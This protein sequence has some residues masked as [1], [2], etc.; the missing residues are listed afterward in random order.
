MEI[1]LKFEELS[2][3]II[4][5][6]HL[7]AESSTKYLLEM[8][9]DPKNILDEALMKGMGIVGQRFRDQQIFVPQ[10]L[11]SA[12]AMKFSMK[13]LEPYLVGD[14]ALSKGKVLLGTVKGDVHDIGKN[15][16]AIML[17]GSGYEVIDIGTGCSAEK[18]YDE[19]LKHKTDIVGMSA[20]LT[21]T[22]VYMKTV[23]EFFKEKNVMVPIIIGGAPL[24]QRFA[25]E[26]GADGFGRNSYDA[27][28]LVDKILNIN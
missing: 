9:I 22:M 8:G 17:Q 23:I 25:D 24:N 2:N 19:Y 18:F 26:I 21:T 15:L 7:D 27:V 13:A 20:L 12:R 28:K 4:E 16:V 1:G 6:K 14:N 3:M 10:V 11:I 5:G